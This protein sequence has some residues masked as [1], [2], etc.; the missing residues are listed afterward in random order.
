MACH[1]DTGHQ[2]YFL[3]DWEKLLQI[4]SDIHE[5]P[6][7]NSNFIGAR[8][9][10]KILKVVVKFTTFVQNRNGLII[11]RRGLLNKSSLYIQNC[12]FLNN[13]VTD[14]IASIQHF[15]LHSIVIES[16][17]FEENLAYTFIQVEHVNNMSIVNTCFRNNAVKYGSIVDLKSSYSINSFF[18]FDSNLVTANV[19]DRGILS[20][21]GLQ[22]VFRNCI[23]Q[24]NVVNGNRSTLTIT[25]SFLTVITTTS[26]EKNKASLEGGAVS[27]RSIKYFYVH[28]RNFTNNLAKRGG[29][30]ILTGECIVILKS[31]YNSNTA[32]EHGGALQILGQIVNITGCRYFNNTAHEG[33]GG[34]INITSDGLHVVSSNFSSNIAYGSGGAISMNKAYKRNIL[35]NNTVFE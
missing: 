25:D 35:F 29:A 20:I 32:K 13:V 10:I 30:L 34:A 6:V 5:L 22:T 27:G 4:I 19:W 17:N 8:K 33:D 16:S 18:N 15:S 26:F 9:N 11:T 3:S 28:K 1:F 12:T 23:F 24:G 7:I 31:S 2:C 14:F 21:N